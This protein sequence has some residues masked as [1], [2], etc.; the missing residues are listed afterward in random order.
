LIQIPSSKIVGINL[1][2]YPGV[3]GVA[4]KLTGA[5]E[6]STTG[7]SIDASFSGFG[8]FGNPTPFEAGVAA[9]FSILNGITPVPFTLT[10]NPSGTYV[11]VFDSAQTSLDVLVVSLVAP[12]TTDKPFKGLNTVTTTVS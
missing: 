2:T 4:L 9:D 5:V 3:L 11:I 12:S 8:S 6:A 10:Q 7:V 1:T